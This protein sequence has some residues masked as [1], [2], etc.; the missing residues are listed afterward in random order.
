MAAM[1]AA[2]TETYLRQYD[3]PMN[4]LKEQEILKKGYTPYIIKDL[5]KFNPLKVAEEFEIFCKWLDRNGRQYRPVL[6]SAYE[7]D[8]IT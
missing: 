6:G 2:A 7:T 4:F 5:G 8:R 3:K 1:S